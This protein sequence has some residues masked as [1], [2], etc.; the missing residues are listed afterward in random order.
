VRS[1]TD[2]FSYEQMESSIRVDANG[3]GD[4]PQP[5]LTH[6]RCVEWNLI[7]P[8]RPFEAQGTRGRLQV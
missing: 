7:P 2:L 8:S 4:L 1:D 5:G 6:M 3:S